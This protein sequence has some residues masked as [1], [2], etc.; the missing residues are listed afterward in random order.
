MLIHH[1]YPYLGVLKWG[2]VVCFTV[3]SYSLIWIPCFLIM[4]DPL[5]RIQLPVMFFII[6]TLFLHGVYG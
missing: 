4:G 6:I 1:I 5:F 3:L 2:F